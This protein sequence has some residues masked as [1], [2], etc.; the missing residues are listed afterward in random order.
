ML[1][2]LKVW[3]KTGDN[4]VSKQC[5]ALFYMFKNFEMPVLPVIYKLLYTLHLSIKHCFA[6]VIQFVYFIPMFKSQVSGSK[7]RLTLHCGMPQIIGSLNIELGD[8]VRM[9]GITTFCGRFNETRKA[10]LSIGNNVD[11]GWQ[12]AFSVGSEIILEDDVRLA[13]KVFLAGFPGHPLNAKARAEGAP[14]TQDQIGHI[15]IKQGA[16]VGT[17][18][19]ILA[20]VTVGKGAIVAAGSVVTKNVPDYCIVAGNPAKVVKSVD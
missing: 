17:G 1:A 18:A 15:I 19:T 7:K 5:L 20:G 10:K 2:E 6:T 8:D 12:N 14:D 16:W 13:G 9:S 4:V 3:V 11:V